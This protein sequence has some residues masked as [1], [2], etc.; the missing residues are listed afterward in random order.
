MAGLLLFLQEWRQKLWQ[1]RAFCWRGVNYLEKMSQD[2]LFLRSPVG[3]SL[4][5]SVGLGVTDMVRAHVSG[6]LEK[7]GTALL[8]PQQALLFSPFAH[9][10]SAG[11]A[12]P[13]MFSTKHP[14]NT[15]KARNTFSSPRLTP[16]TTVS[17]EP[18]GCVNLGTAFDK[19]TPVSL[20]IIP[21]NSSAKITPSV[22]R[23]VDDFSFRP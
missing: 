22:F 6:S 23:P 20:F 11:T 8:K 13:R 10:F 18:H 17:E 19:L 16:N 7:I 12:R 2:T 5:A 4:L 14:P 9:Y 3:R 1:P 21:G 15:T